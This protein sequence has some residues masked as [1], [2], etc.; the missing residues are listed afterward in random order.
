MEMPY[1]TTV[2][3]WKTYFE[4]EVETVKNLES[5]YETTGEI[6]PRLFGWIYAVLNDDLDH[7]IKL[8][9]VKE[10][11]KKAVEFNQAL[12]LENAGLID[13]IEALKADLKKATTPN[14]YPKE[15]LG[16][17]EDDGTMPH[18]VETLEQL[19][20]GHKI[21]SVE[22]DADVPGTSG[23]GYWAADKGTA[24]TLDNG[25]RVFLVPTS[26][27]CAYTEVEDIILNL[28]KVD[29]AIMG[30]GTTDGYNTWHIYAE[31]GDVVELKVGWSSGNPFYY[32]YGFDIQ[33]FD[34]TEET[35]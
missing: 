24:L 20:V 28:D 18:G 15:V 32:G 9:T 27:C 29:H 14:P 12:A 3:D 4:G 7:K 5:H 30:V 11:F 6:H 31:L 16:R 21:V 10:D 2:E 23:G 8:V 33:V 34:P 1:P 17:D 13:E 22:K 25:K 19:V 35:A 26:D